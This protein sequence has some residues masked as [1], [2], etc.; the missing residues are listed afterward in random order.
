[1][2][3]TKCIILYIN[4]TIYSGVLAPV[5]KKYADITY[6][7]ILLKVELNTTTITPTLYYIDGLVI[8]NLKKNIFS[9]AIT[10]RIYGR[11]EASRVKTN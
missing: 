1:M 7:E 4:H 11:V 5:D 6:S 3:S 8:I 2:K 9:Y 10:I